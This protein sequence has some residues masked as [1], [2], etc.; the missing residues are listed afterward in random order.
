MFE[1]VSPLWGICLQNEHDQGKRDRRN[2]SM[3]LIRSGES[4]SDVLSLPDGF[5]Q[6]YAAN[7]WYAVSC[8]ELMRKVRWNDPCRIPNYLISAQS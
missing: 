4:G 2:L 3:Q 5:V 7:Q 1:I 6:I 8:E